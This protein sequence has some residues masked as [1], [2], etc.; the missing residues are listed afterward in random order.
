[1]HLGFL[2][3]LAEHHF[4]LILMVS[5]TVVLGCLFAYS[6]GTN[7][8]LSASLPRLIVVVFGIIEFI[9]VNYYAVT[10]PDRFGR[11]TLT[12]WAARLFYHKIGPPFTGTSG[13][14]T[15][16][17]AP[18]WQLHEWHIGTIYHLSL[19]GLSGWTWAPS[20]AFE[21][22]PMTLQLA[23][24]IPVISSQKRIQLPSRDPSFKLWTLYSPIFI[25]SFVRLLFSDSSVLSQ[26]LY[27]GDRMSCCFYW[28]NLYAKCCAS[29]K[30]M[31][32]YDKMS[33]L[34]YKY[35]TFLP[36]LKIKLQILKIYLHIL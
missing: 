32:R 2:F 12:G 28:H 26:L 27:A 5:T 19:L 14:H 13:P 31:T 30:F 36:I 33:V 25:R 9:F 3:L 23:A 7:C 34:Y 16:T 21:L 29:A 24:D 1:M 17:W 8:P 35:T 11:S 6:I 4:F 22:H 15:V 18:R 20:V 10:W